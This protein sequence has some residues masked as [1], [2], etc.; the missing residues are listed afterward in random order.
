MTKYLLDANCFYNIKNNNFKK[1]NLYQKRDRIVISPIAILEIANLKPEEFDK[2]KEAMR[3]LNYINASI[4]QETPD[5][6]VAKAFGQ[7][8]P[9]KKYRKLINWKRTYIDPV[10]NSNSYESARSKR[11]LDSLRD[12]KKD[13]SDWFVNEVVDGNKEEREVRIEELKEV[14]NES[15]ERKLKH[16]AVSKGKESALNIT[17]YIATICGLSV[18]SG[19]HTE[20]EYQKSITI[21]GFNVDFINN[22]INHYNGKLDSYIFFYQEFQSYMAELGKKPERNA[23]WDLD[24]LHYLDSYDEEL[25]FV[26]TEEFIL[27]IGEKSLQNRII[28]FEEFVKIINTD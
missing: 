25:I 23:V 28:N 15:N 16:I 27:N 19:L 26:T 20:E 3:S 17:G 18:R 11:D 5:D 22:S 12:W 4:L 10:I 21:N 13:I 8:E 14:L 24:Y 6:L 9:Q 2:R 1:Q 7:K